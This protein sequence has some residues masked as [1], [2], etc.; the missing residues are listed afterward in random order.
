MP[1]QGEMKRVGIVLAALAHSDS[2]QFT[3]ILTLSD[4]KRRQNF[5]YLTLQL[6]ICNSEA[7]FGRH[8]LA[9][10]MKVLWQRH[11]D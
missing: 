8:E 11:V 10:A 6:G 2:L 1:S 7:Y 9:L 4:P 5:V 3:L